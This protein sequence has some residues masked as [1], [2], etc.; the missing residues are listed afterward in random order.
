MTPKHIAAALAVAATVASPAAA[1]A[2]GLA[3]PEARGVAAHHAWTSLDWDP[4]LALP[5][6]SLATRWNYIDD[7]NCIRYTR[8]RVDCVTSIVAKNYD[9]TYFSDGTSERTGYAYCD[10]TIDV[11]KNSRNG[12]DRAVDEND[13][14]CDST[15]DLNDG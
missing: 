1:Q 8:W 7:L 5:S 6:Y 2:Y 15:D 13:L 4:S 14:S 11:I 12:R 3:V 10:G 9:R